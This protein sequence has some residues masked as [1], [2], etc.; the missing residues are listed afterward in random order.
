MMGQYRYESEDG[1]YK[2][3]H[4]KKGPAV[5]AICV[6]LKAAERIVDAL[7]R[8]W[9]PDD[10]DCSNCVNVDNE[11]RSGCDP[12]ECKDVDIGFTLETLFNRRA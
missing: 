1:A 12:N 3:F 10:G 7:N 4:D 2:I 11:P 8:G 6:D 9:P 5:I